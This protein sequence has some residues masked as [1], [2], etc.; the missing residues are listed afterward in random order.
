VES[1][2]RSAWPALPFDEWRETKDTLHRYCQMVGKVRLALAPFANHWWHVTL[3]VTVDGLA[4]GMMPAGDGRTVEVGLDLR[5]HVVRVRDSL[6]AVEDFQL[7]PRFACADFH[8]ELVGA[9]RAVGVAVDVDMRPYDLDGPAFYEDHDHEVYD[10]DAASRF[11]Q[12][13]RSSTVVLQ[14]FAGRFN[15]KQ[16]PVQLFWHSFDLAYARFSGRRAPPRD[17]AGRVEAE[18]YSH[19]VIAFG[20]WPG[21]DQIP[22][23]T[24]YSYTAPAPAGYLAQPLTV[25]EAYWHEAAGSA[26]LPYEAVR[27]AEDPRGTLLAFLEDAYRAGARTAGWDLADLATRIAPDTSAG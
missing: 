8:D 2:T 7:R 20:F 9:L 27:T 21:D 18:A 19:E 14:E 1:S 15:G 25:P 13:L 17:G 23:P 11:A 3:Q 10:G 12:M 16:S 24:Y 26:Y 5:E 4:T 22:E 6:G